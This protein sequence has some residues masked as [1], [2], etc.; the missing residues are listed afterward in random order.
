P[1]TTPLTA[2]QPTTR[3]RTLTTAATSRVMVRVV[4]QRPHRC[5]HH[6]YARSATADAVAPSE[7]SPAV[8]ASAPDQTDNSRAI[9]RPATDAAS[10][11]MS[12]RSAASA[13]TAAAAA[14]GPSVSRTPPNSPPGTNSAR[15]STS[16]AR[17]QMPASTAAR[18][19]HGAGA[20][21]CA[22]ATPLAKNATA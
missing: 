22:S 8:N 1:R 6:T 11:P 21:M 12:T 14:P 4:I 15:A 7:I 10:D 9:Y 5:I 17:R 13:D 20:P 18:T 2:P 16:T 19:N 3:T